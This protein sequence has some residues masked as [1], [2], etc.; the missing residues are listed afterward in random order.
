MRR[1]SF[2]NLNGSTTIFTRKLLVRFSCSIAGEYCTI[3]C[4]AQADSLRQE[5]CCG[6]PVKG[7]AHPS[8]PVAVPPSGDLVDQLSC[9]STGQ[10]KPRRSLSTQTFPAQAIKHRRTS[11]GATPLA[12]AQTASRY[13]VL[14]CQCTFVLPILMQ[15]LASHLALRELDFR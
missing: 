6:A 7:L 9:K 2:Q 4:N 15:Q 14:W 11:A 13:S 8:S 5:S 12:N 1:S 10:P 3:S